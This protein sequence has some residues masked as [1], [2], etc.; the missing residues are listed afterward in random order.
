MRRIGKFV[1]VGVYPSVTKRSF[2]WI[3]VLPTLLLACADRTV[4]DG[5]TDE[6]DET[7]GPEPGELYG[8]CMVV[9]DCFDEW[10]VH[11]ANELGFCTSPCSGGCVAELGG[12][13]TQ[14]CLL[15][16]FDEVCALDCA[17]NKTCPAGMRCEQ[18]DAGGEPRSICF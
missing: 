12:T 3:L 13:A 17:G 10:C 1:E 2:A 5:E 8:G 7:Q 6:S 4:G 15:V 11:P 14:T 18:I 16:E 9:E